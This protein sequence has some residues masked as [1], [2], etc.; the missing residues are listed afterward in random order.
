MSFRGS[1][2]T[3]YIYNDGDYDII[4]NAL[5][6]SRSKYLCCSPRPFWGTENERFDMPIVS[7]KVGGL[8]P[9]YGEYE[10][11]IDR[12]EGVKTNTDIKIV[13]ICDGGEVVLITKH[14][15]GDIAVS[16]MVAKTE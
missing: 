8:S 1:F 15:N 16:E 6:K 2:T 12:I 4:R 3:E 13:V 9:D 5:E 11:I 14:P 10:E 7:G